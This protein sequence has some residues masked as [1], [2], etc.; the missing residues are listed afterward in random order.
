[1]SQECNEREK[2]AGKG[3]F[4]AGERMEQS[5]PDEELRAL[6]AGANAVKTG[7]WSATL[8]VKMHAKDPSRLIRVTD[9]AQGLT[10]RSMKK[11]GNKTL[12]LEKV[13]RVHLDK[14][15]KSVKLDVSGY[16]S[17]AFEFAN[18]S[19]LVYGERLQRYVGFL[20]QQARSRNADH[21]LRNLWE[22]ADKNHDNALQEDEFVD[23]LR[24]ELHIDLKQSF[25]ARKLMEFHDENKDGVID[26][27]EFQRMLKHLQNPPAVIMEIFLQYGGFDGILSESDLAEFLVSEQKVPTE[28]AA[29]SMARH[30]ISKL[31]NSTH[32][33][34]FH[35]HGSTNGLTVLQFMQYLFSEEHNSAQENITAKAP[36]HD[37]TQSLS[38]YYINSSHN[39]YLSGNQLTGDAD[40]KMYGRAVELGAR[41]VELD[42]WD[43]KLGDPIITHGHTL[44]SEISLASAVQEINAWAFRFTDTPFILSIENHCSPPQQK[45]M[46]EA[47]VTTFGE[48]IA[49]HPGGAS[50]P[51]KELPSPAELKGK[52]LIK[53]KIKPESP[54]EFKQIVYF[55]GAKFKDWPTSLALNAYE[56]HSFSETAVEEFLVNAMVDKK[57]MSLVEYNKYH[58]SRIYP[59]GTRVA[60]DN[61]D[62]VLPW[63][64]ACQVVA[65]NF[66]TMNSSLASNLA[67]F[68]LNSGCGYVLQPDRFSSASSKPPPPK[69]RVAVTVVLAMQVPNLVEPKHGVSSYVVVR[70]FDGS[71]DELKKDEYR[72]RSVRDNDFDPVYTETQKVSKKKLGSGTFLTSPFEIIIENRD[73]ACIQLWIMNDTKGRDYRLAVGL[74]A[75][76]ELRPGYRWVTLHDHAGRSLP[77]YRGILCKFE[78]L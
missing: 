75:T 22:K 31:G 43:G 49:V 53:S 10:W 24:L 44:T 50:A 59:K 57:Q 18:A 6:K 52:V 16:K 29:M 28:A 40:L 4:K 23:F 65:L 8:H 66:Q 1:M 17:Y 41:C 20:Q 27:N 76:R 15:K 42:V 74:V 46:A 36:Y 21:E 60:S 38:K 72:T 26:Y 48:R 35:L 45:K 63:N 25:T 47:M 69:L 33:M 58:L 67:M 19:D 2:A 56:M 7:S 32:P 71:E 77:S 14:D 54:D 78:F 62:P 12:P 51:M 3:A 73:T 37:M 9:D 13:R 39:T 61:Y 34:H 30:I 64:H 68:S 5:F 55:V 70:K 11:G